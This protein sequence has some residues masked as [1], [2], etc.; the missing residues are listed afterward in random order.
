VVVGGGGL[1]ACGGGVDCSMP[2]GL[3]DEQRA[4]RR[5][6]AYVERSP[7]AQQR[8]ELC[9]FFTSAGADACGQC[10][11]NLGPVNPQGYCSSFVVRS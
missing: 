3:T 11:L 4:Q 10:T 8:C 5:T 6:L 1:A 9:N 7:N 2:P